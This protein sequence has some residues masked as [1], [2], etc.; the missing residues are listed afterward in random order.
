MEPKSVL[1]AILL[2][3]NSHITQIR[4]TTTISI[5]QLI[6]T[7]TIKP[8]ENHLYVEAVNNNPSPIALSNLAI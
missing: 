5:L 1:E 4:L 2:H 7:K 8:K 6:I 3:P